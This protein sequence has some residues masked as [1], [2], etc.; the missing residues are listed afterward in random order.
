MFDF[1]LWTETGVRIQN[2]SMGCVT[3][4]PL[5]GSIR[6]GLPSCPGWSSCA[7]RQVWVTA[8]WFFY[9]ITQSTSKPVRCCVEFCYRP[10]FCPEVIQVSLFRWAVCLFPV[11][12]ISIE[13][14]LY[15]KHEYLLHLNATCNR[16]LFVFCSLSVLH[17]IMGEGVFLEGV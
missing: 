5:G 6:S 17:C 2:K 8:I 13:F 4:S 16:F 10:F 15:R 9:C 1:F 11:C 3:C 12:L 7:W 14:I